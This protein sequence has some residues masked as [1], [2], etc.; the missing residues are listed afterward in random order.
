[1]PLVVFLRRSTAAAS[2]RV[3]LAAYTLEVAWQAYVAGIF[4]IGFSTIG[5]T[6]RFGISPFDTAFTGPHDNLSARFQ[7]GVAERGRATNLDTTQ[8]GVCTVTV[9][10]RDGLLNPDNASSPLYGLLEYR[11]QPLRLRGVYQGV[12]YPIF[13]GHVDSITW[14]PLGRGKAV[15]EIRAVDLFYWLDSVKPTIAATGATSTGAALGKLLDAVGWIDPQARSLDAGDNLPGFSAD[16]TKTGLQIARDL[17]D[18]ERGVFY[19][20]AA[21][22]ATFESRQSRALRPVAAT[23]TDDMTRVSPTIDH[24][25]I[26]NV[27]RV[28]R[29][30]TG[31]Q[32]TATD[33]DSINKFGYHEGLNLE[34]PYLISDSQTD[35]LANYVLSQ[36][37]KPRRP[38]RDFQIDNRLPSTLR[39]ALG[40]DLSD[41]VSVSEAE[42]G[43]AGVYHIERVRHEIA[44]RGRRH[45]TGWVL[46][47]KPAY[48]PMVIGTSQIAANGATVGPQLV[49]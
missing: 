33:G 27:V 13:Y 29:T 41:V 38:L 14:T 5:G 25:L 43:T 16:G 7:H 21:G 12:T 4:T 9:R 34:T 44:Q 26:E 28:K 8:A 1:M 2:N 11:K 35:A 47:K 46:S 17:L 40:R 15:A 42:G 32:A 3:A 6:D 23:I 45:S 19:I 22:V 31:Y 36:T 20:S 18:A 37:A 49:Y 48:T 10:D 24:R 39:Q 30:Q